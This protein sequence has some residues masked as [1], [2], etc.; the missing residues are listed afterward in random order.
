MRVLRI[1]AYEGSEDDVNG[2]LS[3]SMVHKIP[4]LFHTGL[5]KDGVIIN[6]VARIDVTPENTKPLSAI[7]R[8]RKD[9]YES[10]DGAIDGNRGQDS[11]IA[12]WLDMLNKV[13]RDLKGLEAFKRSVDEA[14]N[15]GDGAYRP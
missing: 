10:I 6:E 4:T 11:N 2:M 3:R 1:L 12:R 7:E 14:L 5:R 9:L 8:L 15:T 13:E